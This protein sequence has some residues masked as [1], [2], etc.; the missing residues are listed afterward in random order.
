MSDKSV[1]IHSPQRAQEGIGHMYDGLDMAA[2]YITTYAPHSLRQTVENVYKEV[3][4]LAEELSYYIEE[5]DVEEE[6]EY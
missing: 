3:D 6:K 4:Q 1:S 5:D 2:K